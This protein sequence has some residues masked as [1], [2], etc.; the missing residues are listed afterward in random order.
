M[1]KS[2]EL[3]NFCCSFFSFWFLNNFLISF[4]GVSIIYPLVVKW[5]KKPST[6]TNG[7]N[8]FFSSFETFP[9]DKT[10][11]VQSLLT[12]LTY[13]HG[14][15]CKFRGSSPM[16]PDIS[17]Y[18]SITTRYTWYKWTNT[19]VKNYLSYQSQ[20]QET[21]LQWPNHHAFPLKHKNTNVKEFHFQSSTKRF[22]V[23]VKKHTVI[24]CTVNMQS[25]HWR[26]IS[27]SL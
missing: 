1:D 13:L 18:L 12:S 15:Q 3:F 27:S 24:P 16:C 25:G 20:G 6:T 26:D 21:P 5:K 22:S 8:N 17:M 19:W 2:H 11:Q 14:S 9:E 7:I 23:S 10:S 4:K